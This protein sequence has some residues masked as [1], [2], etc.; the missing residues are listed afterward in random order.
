M[1]QSR[2]EKLWERPAS[3]NPES[4]TVAVL[5]YAP[6]MVSPALD[7]WALKTVSNRLT[8]NE[9]LMYK[10]AKTEYHHKRYQTTTKSFMFD[11]NADDGAPSLKIPEDV[12]VP[13]DLQK[14]NDQFKALKPSDCEDMQPKGQE[15]VNQISRQYHVSYWQICLFG[16][17]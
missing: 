1:M 15:R 17:I 13:S 16:K 4:W 14:E 10:P 9:M 5:E 12:Y 6:A 7:S 3:E 8:N 2:S 11:N